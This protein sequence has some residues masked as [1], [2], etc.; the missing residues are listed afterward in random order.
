MTTADYV[1]DIEVYQNIFTMSVKCAQTGTRWLFEISHRRNDHAAMM[2]FIHWLQ[3]NNARMVGF[4]NYGFDYPVIH[5][6]LTAPVPPSN[7]QIYEFVNRI[8]NVHD[9]SR[10]KHIIWDRDQL[11]LQLD[12]FKIHHFDNKAR[13]TSLK[14]IEFNMR[15]ANVQEL[16]FPPGSWLT[17]EQMDVLITYNNH[18]VDQ[19]EKFYRLSSDA[20]RFREELSVKYSRNFLN[21]NDT[22][23]GKDYFIMELERL[24][25]GSCYEQSGGS[26]RP[27]QT[28][29]ESIPLADVIFP[30]IRFKRPEFIRTH[31]WLLSQVVTDT[32]GF[33]K[34]PK[35]KRGTD[36]SEE[37]HYEE[38]VLDKRM[39]PCV[40]N[41]FKFVFGTG[42]IH[43]SVASQTLHSTDTHVIQDWDVSSFYPN[44]AI[45]NRL[46][47]EH[48]S[49]QFCDIYKDVYEM[50]K[51]YGKN[52]PENAMLKLALNGTYGD[53]NNPYSPFYDPKYTMAITI[54]GQ[55]LI[56]LLADYLMDVPGLEMIQVNTDGLTI[57]IP[58]N[59]EC[60]VK[61]I[62]DWWQA[63]TL[64]ELEDAT[65]NRMMIRDVNSYIGEGAD[66]KLKRKGAYE[67]CIDKPGAKGNLGWHQN[68]S[69][70]IIPMAAEAALVRGV[71]VRQFI[72]QHTN[73]F[74][75]MLRTKVPRSSRLMLHDGSSLWPDGERQLQ[76]ICR[77]YISKTGGELVKVMPPLAKAPDKE[78]RIGINV[79]WLAT[80]CNDILQADGRTINYEYYIQ[81]AEK[82]VN[83]VIGTIAT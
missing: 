73:I 39:P 55:L 1:Y 44:L 14:I 52:T 13:M 36:G 67:Y 30:W 46:Y 77:Y 12:L 40:I 65:Y 23:I 38:D 58:R 80:E 62:T 66:G 37:D 42:G 79:G 61:R 35:K 69:A 50:R 4:N 49:S 34:K 75:F 56:C 24:L 7:R 11:V 72:T 33:F 31:E 17:D 16:P 64:L 6:I 45:V 76:N 43:G 81:E 20:I 74:D 51:T 83:P 21:H 71:P 18:D 29:R 10:F 5:Y 60:A 82:L 41:K 47:P 25:P 15:S 28:P 57:R 9:D 19:T 32:K 53:S 8:I 70:L 27:R 59:Q 3:Y 54:N 22:K 68:H 63:H 78:R 48:L 26:R 2:Q